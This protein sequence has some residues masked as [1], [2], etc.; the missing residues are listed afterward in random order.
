M[1][2]SLIAQ[3]IICEKSFRHHKGK[4]GKFCCIAC[5]RVAQRAGSYKHGPKPTTYRAPCAN[6]GEEVIKSRSRKRNGQKSDK[7]FCNRDCYDAH[8]RA[9]IEARVSTCPRCKEVFKVPGGKQSR[10]YC[11]EVCW[12][13]EKKAKPTNC[14]N[15]GCLF[16]ALKFNHKRREYVSANNY[17]TCSEAC[18]RAWWSNNQ[19]RKD[20]ISAA[21]TGEKHPHWQGGSHSLSGRGVG[22]QKARLEARKRAGFKC[23]TCG[24]SEADHL[25]KHRQTLHVNHKIPYHQ[26]T[27]GNPNRPSNLEA[28]C[29][30]CHMK[31]DW[32]WRRENPVQMTLAR[33]KW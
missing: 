28:L 13:A 19:V 14:V 18:N 11:S 30:S 20:K 3:C 15:C 25:A 2:G 8:R 33:L 21:F 6:C 7:L 10:I 32:K 1:A 24:M 16:T 29:V 12:K 17:K 27:S 26:H 5:Y 9:I 31:A 23:Q 22:W 4:S